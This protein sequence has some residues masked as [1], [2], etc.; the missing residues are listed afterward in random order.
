MPREA[1]AETK[2]RTAKA[3]IRRLHIELNRANKSAN[4]Y[5]ARAA[6]AEQEAAEWKQ[7]FDILLRRDQQKK[8]GA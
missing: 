7:R 4:E 3:D 6:K 1:S 2:L 8:G 5:R